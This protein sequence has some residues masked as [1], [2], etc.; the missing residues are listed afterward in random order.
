MCIIESMKS[1]TFQVQSI[2][3]IAGRP[4]EKLNKEGKKIYFEGT[5]EQCLKFRPYF[6]Q[7][8]TYKSRSTCIVE[9]TD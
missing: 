1:K 4:G 9:V 5:E 8:Q 6:P 7:W 3:C 2:H